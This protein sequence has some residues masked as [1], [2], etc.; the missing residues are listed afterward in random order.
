MQS[1]P[2]DRI[3]AYAQAISG[4]VTAEGHATEAADELFRFARTFEGNEGLRN[5]LVD[6]SLPVERRLALVDE[7]IGAT[8]LTVTRAAITFVV[9]A[10]RA[11]DLPAIVDRYSELA[12]A[13]RDR[14]VAE[15]RSAVALDDS[16]VERLA[17]SLSSATGKQMLEGK[18]P[19]AV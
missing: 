7:L 5:A 6:A 17:E 13:T 16:T 12:A 8:A 1:D 3:E 10:G 9:T 19:I 14:A 4:V 15:V 18:Q 2:M 11:S